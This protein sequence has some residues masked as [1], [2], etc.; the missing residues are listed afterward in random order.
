[1]TS[2]ASDRFLRQVFV[3]TSQNNS[4]LHAARLEVHGFRPVHGVEADGQAARP[5][6]VAHERHEN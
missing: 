2:G 6:V 5:E 4:Q 1:M 3:V